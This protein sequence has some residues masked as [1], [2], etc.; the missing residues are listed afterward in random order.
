MTL[1]HSTFSVQIHPGPK[2]FIHISGLLSLFEHYDSIV[3]GENLKTPVYPIWLI[4][5]ESHF[6]VLFG[7]QFGLERNSMADRRPIGNISKS[8]YN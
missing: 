6:T 1:D 8:L 2:T 5:S 7:M 3:V 4:C